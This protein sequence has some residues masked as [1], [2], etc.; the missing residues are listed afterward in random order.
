MWVFGFG[1]DGTMK[2]A[3]ILV[4]TQSFC[5]YQ[6][7]HSCNLQSK[8]YINKLVYASFQLYNSPGTIC[9]DLKVIN[10]AALE[11]LDAL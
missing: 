5:E 1:E 10:L 7:L 9:L 4:F 8:S 11:F 2:S 6:Y 3:T